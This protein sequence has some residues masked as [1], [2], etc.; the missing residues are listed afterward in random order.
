T[1]A[2][3]GTRAEPVDLIARFP[4]RRPFLYEAMEDRCSPNGTTNLD[5]E[6]AMVV[7]PV[8]ALGTIEVGGVPGVADGPV[9]VGVLCATLRDSPLGELSTTLHT[10]ATVSQ[11]YVEV[12]SIEL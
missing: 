5:V 8:A 11:L 9:E 7:A 10:T 2:L 1:I 3:E 4:V 12:A 6:L